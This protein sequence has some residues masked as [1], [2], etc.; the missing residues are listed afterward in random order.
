MCLTFEQPAAVSWCVC[1]SAEVCP[2][3]WL[4]RTCLHLVCGGDCGCCK[5]TLLQRSFHRAWLYDS[6]S[7]NQHAL[8]VETGPAVCN[9]G[10]TPCHSCIQGASTVQSDYSA[11]KTSM[12][13]VGC[14]CAWCHLAVPGA[15]ELSRKSSHYYMDIDITLGL[16]RCVTAALKRALIY[17]SKSTL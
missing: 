5:P 12:D 6:K 14:S 15:L 17:S 2:R 9:S 8:A 3:T 1:F 16:R 7:V 11:C 10:A 13:S 4:G